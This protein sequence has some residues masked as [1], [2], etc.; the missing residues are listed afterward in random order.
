MEIPTKINN[1]IQRI[2]KSEDEWKALYMASWGCV[3]HWLEPEFKVKHPDLWEKAL[4]LGLPASKK[5]YQEYTPAELCG[6][7]KSKDTEFTLGHLQ[8]LFSLFEELVNELC[9]LVCDGQEIRSYKFENLKKF[10]SGDKPYDGFKINITEND[11][12]ELELAKETRNCFIHNNSKVDEHWLE[13]F[14][15]ARDKNSTAQIGDKLP[16]N[17]YQIEDWHELVVKIIS[18]IKKTVINL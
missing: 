8:T 1:I 5:K 6:I 7:L 4:R 18:K 17:F 9:P 12:K 16:V 2:L 10:L 11:F 13:A 15:E 3:L 14:R